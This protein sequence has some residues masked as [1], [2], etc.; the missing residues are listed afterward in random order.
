M[1]YSP[2]F[3]VPSFSSQ[4]LHL[5]STSLYGPLIDS[6]ASFMVP[7]HFVI[8]IQWASEPLEFQIHLKYRN[9]LKL[10]HWYRFTSF[11]SYW[12]RKKDFIN[13]RLLSSFLY[14]ILKQRNVSTFFDSKISILIHAIT[15][16][17]NSD[18]HKF[19][20][21]LNDFYSLFGNFEKAVNSFMAFIEK[22]FHLYANGNLNCRAI[23]DF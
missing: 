14:F 23:L 21:C 17:W 3:L 5:P 22:I 7:T 4:D 20:T 10:M 8:Y 12:E 15:D 16:L 13:Q 18:F 1:N 19:S 9:R 6:S 11:W 2:F